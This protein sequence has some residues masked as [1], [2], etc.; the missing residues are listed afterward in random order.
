MAINSKLQ[1]LIVDYLK[2]NNVS[3]RKFATAIGV[4]ETTFGTYVRMT[5][6]MSV[7]IM[8]KILT[9]YPG[10][11]AVLINYLRGNTE[12][13]SEKGTAATNNDEAAVIKEREELL[14]DLDAFRTLAI[15]N[16]KAIL[17]LTRGGGQTQTTE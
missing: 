6:S 1:Q 12:E 13:N 10:V 17:N 15:Q 2:E 4:S 3:Q 11:R 9:E 5:S 7:E 16:A 8:D 14:K